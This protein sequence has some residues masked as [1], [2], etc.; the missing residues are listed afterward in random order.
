MGTYGARFW[1]RAKCRESGHWS[2]SLEHEASPANGRRGTAL[3]RFNRIPAGF[4]KKMRSEGRGR[5]ILLSVGDK[6]VTSVELGGWRNRGWPPGAST[7]MG[8]APGL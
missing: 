2:W 1:G 3:G 7:F 5:L 4:V 6:D 8:D